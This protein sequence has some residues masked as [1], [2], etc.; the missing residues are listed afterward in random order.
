V[1]GRQP[2]GPRR[3][4]QHTLNHEGID[5]DQCIL[6]Q[7]QGEQGNFLRLAPIRSEVTA[8]PKEDAIIGTIPVLHDIE[9]LVNL[10]P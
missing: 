5:V 3:L 9:A 8:V 7:V 6:E 1:L 10:A 2:G 4:A